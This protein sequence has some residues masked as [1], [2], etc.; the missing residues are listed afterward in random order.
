MHHRQH[1]R[2]LL[3]PR[4]FLHIRGSS[5]AQISQKSAVQL[6]C[7]G[8]SVPSSL[9][10]NSTLRRPQDPCVGSLDDAASTPT[11]CQCLSFTRLFSHMLIWSTGLFSRK[12]VSFRPQDPCVGSLDDAASTLTTCQCVALTRLFS[13]I[14]ISSTGLF[15]RIQ[16]SF[17]P[18]DPCVGSLD[19]AASKNEL[20]RLFHRSKE[21]NRR[22]KRPVNQINTNEKRPVKETHELVFFANNE[23]VRRFHRSFFVYIDLIYGSLFTSIGLFSCM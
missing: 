13:N 4:F 6:P 9:L 2:I 16:L 20:V 22:E 7:T 15:S 23:S 10:R 18:Q 1:L 3:L 14:Y 21:T 8:N 5:S 19:D 17:R 12:Y 11:I